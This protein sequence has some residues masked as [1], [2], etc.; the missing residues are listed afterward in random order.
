[1][2][3][4]KGAT[5]NVDEADDSD[6]MA[7]QSNGDAGLVRPPA[8]ASQEGKGEL[9]LEQAISL[10]KSEREAYIEFQHQAFTDTAGLRRH[11]ESAEQQ[12]RES[13]EII[14]QLDC[15][16]AISELQAQNRNSKY[17]ND[18]QE[19]NSLIRSGARLTIN[20]SSAQRQRF[21]NNV[22]G[23]R[24]KNG[25]L[26]TLKGLLPMLRESAWSLWKG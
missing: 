14:Q 6:V 17:Q 15:W 18:T 11:L 3:R 25:L 19:R 5:T 12:C 9:N 24:M 1:M 2:I 8:N 20:K 23:L 21:E 10:L 26:V 7:M 13:A 16:R 22:K 4:R